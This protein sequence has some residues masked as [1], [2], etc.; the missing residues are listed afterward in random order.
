MVTVTYRRSERIRNIKFYVLNRDEVCTAET[1]VC[2]FQHHVK[3]SLRKDL[4]FSIRRDEN[5]SRTSII[6]HRIHTRHILSVEAAEIKRGKA[7]TVT[8][9]IGHIRHILSIE[10]ADIKRGKAATVREHIAHI[11]HILSVEAT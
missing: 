5:D 6:E 2:C 11:P 10:T 7:A 4:F 9:H 3:V 1:A 8:E